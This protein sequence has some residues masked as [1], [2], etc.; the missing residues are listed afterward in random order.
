MR[1]I[2]RYYTHII[3]RIM[4]RGLLLRLLCV[5]RGVLYAYYTPHIILPYKDGCHA[6]SFSFY[7]TQPFIP[8]NC[9]LMFHLSISTPR[10]SVQFVKNYSLLNRNSARRDRP[11]AL[12]ASPDFARMTMSSWGKSCAP[13]PALART[14]SPTPTNRCICSLSKFVISSNGSHPWDVG[15]KN[16]LVISWSTW[17]QRSSS[18]AASR[19]RTAS[20]TFSSGTSSS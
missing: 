5:M 7:E 11:T 16:G 3:R 17:R 2:I 15:F 12:F 10:Q 1:R 14:A 8:R 13:P 20:P 9:R 19:R 18:K 4:C 6:N